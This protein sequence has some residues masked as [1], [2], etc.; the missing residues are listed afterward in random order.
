MPILCRFLLCSNLI[1]C[2]TK[3]A[4]FRLSLCV[5][6]ELLSIFCAAWWICSI[7]TL[8]KFLFED[9]KRIFVLKTKKIILKTKTDICLE[10]KIIILLW[11]QKENLVLKT[12]TKFCF[13]DRKRI[14]FSK[15]KQ[16]SVLETKKK[17]RI[18]NPNETSYKSLE[19]LC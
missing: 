17:K 7:L 9:K 2:L 10:D 6:V 16:N 15:Q 5:W 12:K 11:R 3:C 1:P 4:T 8:T 18:P 13:E 19:I 14:W